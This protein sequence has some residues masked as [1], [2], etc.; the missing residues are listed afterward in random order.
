M[1]YLRALVLFWEP[2]DIISHMSREVVSRG[3]TIKC[4]QGDQF[5]EAVVDL[6][7]LRKRNILLNCPYGN[8][9]I[10][11]KSNDMGGYVEAFFDCS[12]CGT[13]Y[14]ANIEE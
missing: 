12:K 2:F 9:I 5:F 8:F 13:V 11:V 7:Q 6:N 10:E 4:P 3:V 14:S 1:G